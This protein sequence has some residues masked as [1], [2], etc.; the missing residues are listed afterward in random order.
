MNNIFLFFAVFI[1]CALF[2]CKSSSKLITEH[3]AMSHKCEI[4]DS[5][6]NNTTLKK[7]IGIENPKRSI[8]S[9]RFIDTKKKDFKGCELIYFSDKNSSPIEAF[10]IPEP[11]YSLNTGQYRDIVLFDYKIQ[12]DTINLSLSA[13][14]IKNQFEK[15]GIPY[16]LF[17]ITIDKKG[18]IRIVDVTI[19]PIRETP[20]FIDYDKI[21]E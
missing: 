8:P 21:K 20:P 4:L 9:I 5:I 7:V 14:H 12:N 18:Q 13:A 6:L 2:S 17:K 3:I 15:E 1:I 10:V 16:F 19:R 11:T